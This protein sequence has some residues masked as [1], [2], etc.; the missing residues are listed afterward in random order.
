LQYK[1]INVFSLP[2]P[3]REAEKAAAVFVREHSE[4]G[5]K[6][7]SSEKGKKKFSSC[8][9]ISLLT[10]HAEMETRKKQKNVNE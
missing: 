8:F 1:F 10:A 3:R 2:H 6:K 4:S 7:T 9:E 5:V